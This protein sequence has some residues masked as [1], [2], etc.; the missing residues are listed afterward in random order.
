MKILIIGLS[1]CFGTEFKNLCPKNS[2]KLVGFRSSKLNI[3]RSDDL[4]LGK[5]LQSLWSSSK[6]CFKEVSLEFDKAV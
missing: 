5:T 4:S 3:L 1:G 2:I 6:I